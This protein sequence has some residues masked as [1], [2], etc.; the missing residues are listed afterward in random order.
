VAHTDSVFTGSIPALYDQHLGPLL[1]KPYAE[2]LAARVARIA[3]GRVLEIAAG[4]GIVTRELIRTLH[5][6][7]EIVATDLDQPMLDFA[8]AQP[9]ATRAIWRQADALSL[10]YEVESF[11]TVVC[12]FGV[13]FFPDKTA[14]YC[15]ARRVLKPG[16][17]FI[18]SVWDSLERN[19][20][21][22]IVSD[23]VAALFPSDPP[24][25]LE[26]TPYIYYDID[27]IRGELAAAG[28][29]SMEA[30]TVQ[31]Y[32]RAPSSRDAVIG[33][34]QGSP[35]RREIEARDPEGLSTATDAAATA[36]A[37]RFG[38][39]PISAKMQARVIT[40]TA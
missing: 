7:V 31:G 2:D 12:Q 6:A 30:E 36:V 10:P 23:A 32:S 33:L 19:E 4:T 39:G 20:L 27:A 17:R 15:E 24:R 9:G 40:A 38:S 5:E 3:P 37:A 26:R 13:M 35:L 21:S 34:C 1:F 18:F 25:F 22:Q 8:A 28:F 11:D 14:A 16:G 29:S